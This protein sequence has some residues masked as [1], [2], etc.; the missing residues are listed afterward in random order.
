MIRYHE[1][2]GM[3][4]MPGH[5]ESGGEVRIAPERLNEFIRG[6]CRRAGCDDEE[7]SAI[8]DHLVDANLTGHDSHGACKIPE[9]VSVMRDGRLRLG[10]RAQIVGD[11]GA[12]LVV[13]GNLGVG[14]VV[15]RQAMEMGMA[16][17]RQ[18]GVAVVALRRA[19]HIGR[20]GAWAEQCAAAG[21]ASMHYVNVIGHLPYVAPFGGRDGRLAT[22]P[23]C[24]A[25]P[26]AGQPPV[27]LDMATSKVA[28]GKL[29]V[30]A[31][32]GASAPP[33]AVI[34]AEGNDSLDPNVMFATPKGAMLPF[35]DHKGYALAVL[36]DLM[37]GA[38]GGGGCN[39]PENS[40]SST[41]INSMLSIIIRCD[42]LGDPAAIAAEAGGFAAW[43]KSSRLRP[44]V[45]AILLPGEPERARRAARQR[46]G[47]PL[48]R[49][50]WGQLLDTARGVGCTVDEAAL[51]AAP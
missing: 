45:E 22:N 30:A 20:I 46:S 9:Y 21:F 35:G 2:N 38:L 7:A 25:L 16:R 19:H 40:G 5:Q 26:L 24:A 14:Q 31:N 42:A 10:Q 3:R 34:D 37:A 13:D 36:C 32:K 39:R 51:L 29:L 11:N 41:A 8:A 1:E 43:A 48:D 6:I 50:T 12:V 47:I 18:F 15:A 33:D 27:V 28:W 44:G 49:T 4:I 17:A 23:F